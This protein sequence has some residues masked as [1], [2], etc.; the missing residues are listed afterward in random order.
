ML[1]F[2]C[3]EAIRSIDYNSPSSPSPPPELIKKMEAA[4]KDIGHTEIRSGSVDLQ[5]ALPAVKKGTDARTK[6]LT[7]A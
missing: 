2:T 6:E 1:V 3:G 5:V 7:S 4:T